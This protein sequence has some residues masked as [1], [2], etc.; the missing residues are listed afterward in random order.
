M[1]RQQFKERVAL[2]VIA[3]IED[4]FDRSSKEKKP[5]SFFSQEVDDIL[6]TVERYDAEIAELI[7][8]KI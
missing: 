7:H 8:D 3:I 5:M 4:E 2:M 1:N 6:R